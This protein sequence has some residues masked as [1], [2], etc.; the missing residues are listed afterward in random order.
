MACASSTVCWLHLQGN[1]L[2][3]G[4]FAVIW[5]MLRQPFTEFFSRAGSASQRVETWLCLPPRT[6]STRIQSRKWLF[7]QVLGGGINSCIWRSS[8]ILKLCTVTST[9]KWAVLTVLWIGF[10]HWASI[11]LVCACMLYYCNT[12]GGPCLPSVLWHCWLGHLIRK[13]P[14]P[15]WPMCLVGVGR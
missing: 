14:S 9:L 7:P 12:V 10:S 4:V 8:C 2:T 3:P 1:R 13:N 6:F 11:H 15:I 5:L